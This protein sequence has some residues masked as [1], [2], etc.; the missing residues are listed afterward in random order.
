MA[1]SDPALVPSLSNEVKERI[2]L[3]EQFRLQ[4]RS[5]VENENEERP[6]GKKGGFISFLSS[7]LG[8]LIL[9]SLIVPIL[10]GLYTYLHQREDER[11][12]NNRQ[13]VKL[14]NEFDWR[15]SD[16]ENQRVNPLRGDEQSARG[17]IWGVIVGGDNYHPT[18]P[19]FRD[20]HLGGIVTQLRNLGFA[21]PSNVALSTIHDIQ[22][23]TIKTIP[24]GILGQQVQALRVF[25]SRIA[26]KTGFWNLLL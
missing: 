26:P 8:L 11:T 5:K 17:Y 19:E 23:E 7:K 6:S 13:I 24:P 1:E 4:I 22:N 18:M 20:V 14:L 3:E 12:A 2:V 21:D 10:G 16:I 9:G 25:G 15:V